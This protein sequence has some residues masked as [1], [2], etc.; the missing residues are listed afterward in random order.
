MSN[1]TDWTWDAARNEYYY[2]SA[3]EGANV[4]QTGL[5][6]YVKGSDIL[7]PNIP[8]IANSDP[9]TTSSKL[10]NSHTPSHQK[11]NS[12]PE[13]SKTTTK[14]EG[15]LKGFF[16]RPE[17]EKLYPNSKIKIPGAEF[18]VR[19]RLVRAIW[20]ETV[21]E[22]VKR[23]ADIQQVI[24]WFKTTRTEHADV[25]AKAITFQPAK[26][27]IKPKGWKT[28]YKIEGMVQGRRIVA[29]PDTGAEVNVIAESLATDLSLTID[30][31]SETTLRLASGRIVKT[32]GTVEVPWRYDGERK[33][34]N[35]I[36][37]VLANC[38]SNLILG[39]KFLGMDFKSRLKKYLRP[40]TS[41]LGAR[42]LGTERKRVQGYLNGNKSYALPDFGS[43]VLL[44]SGSYARRHGLTVDRSAQRRI[45]LAYPDGS[46]GYT[47]GVV[48]DISWSFGD[49]YMESTTYMKSFHVLERLPVDIILS[50]DVLYESNAY[51]EFS[52]YFFDLDDDSI[53]AELH[54]LHGVKH[55]GGYSDRLKNLYARHIKNGMYRNRNIILA[56]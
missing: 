43:D 32:K 26:G 48:D 36:C 29:D 50:N 52:R 13:T 5:R 17:Y 31:Y 35:L 34:Y 15:R 51:T 54:G 25:Q 10:E 22:S 56:N 37:H 24:Q 27:S 45:E 4:Y 39:S 33:T 30:G 19:G 14:T 44:I 18:F 55:V 12:D 41:L 3:S 16:G 11:F 2:Y 9:S 20:H 6:I 42:L 40:V 21:T 47:N 8:R 1:F 49:E 46:R 28:C 23:A 7:Q 53:E 38:T